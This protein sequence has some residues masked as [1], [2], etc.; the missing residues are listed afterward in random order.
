MPYCIAEALFNAASGDF[1]NG[2]AFAGTNAYKATKIQPVKEIF[3]E[4]NHEFYKASNVSKKNI[5]NAVLV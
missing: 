4:L 2:F 3:D 5:R 1:D